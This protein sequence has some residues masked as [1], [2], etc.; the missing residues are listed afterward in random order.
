MGVTGLLNLEPWWR[1]GVAILIGA[2]VGLEREFVQQ[3]HGEPDFAGIRTFSLM[4]LLGAVAGF[5]ARERGVL[6]FAVAYGGLALLVWISYQG[7]IRRGREEG[8]TTEVAALLVPLLGAMA[9]WGTAEIAIA[10]GVITAVVLSLKPRLH[11][12]ARRMSTEDL[13]ATLEFAL[14]AAVILPLLPDRTFGPFDVLNPYEIWLL[15]VLVSGVGFVGYVLIKWLGAERGIGLTGVLGGLASSTATTLSFA[16]RSKR[17]PALS[18]DFGRAIVLASTM[19]FPRVL[20]EVL[21]VNRALVGSLLLPVG[22]MF[23]T[24]WV[25]FAVFAHRQESGDQSDQEAVELTNPL[26]VWTAVKFALLFAVVLVATKAADW[27]FGTAGVYMASV[28]AGLT[29][30]DSITLSVSELA[31]VGQIGP[32]V[33]SVAI[34]V[35]V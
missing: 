11:A 9:V 25:F 13:W 2:L 31:A 22:T 28:I 12:V 29:D 14:V 21:A 17:S 19:M 1:F 20:V 24:G 35:A 26:N 27:F 6:V 23:L 10:L 32:R 15:V 7:D 16:G 30:V 5:V 18:R 8:V 33:A 3:R 34:M 4:A